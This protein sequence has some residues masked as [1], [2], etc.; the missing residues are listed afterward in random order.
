MTVAALVDASIYGGGYDFTTDTNNVKLAADV[1]EK[2]ATTFAS[3]GWSEVAAGLNAASLEVSGF[4]Q[5]GTGQVD[6]TAWTNLAADGV[7]FTVTPTEV[8][9]DVA[10]FLNT[11]ETSYSLFGPVG[12]LTP[13]SIKSPHTRG[14]YGLI[15][16][17][18]AK[19]KGNVSAT[20]ALGSA[21]QLTA[22][23]ATQYVYAVLHVFTAG[24]TITVQVQSDDASNF[25]S[26]TT[27][28]TI[29]PI[30]TAGGTLLT[31]VAGPITDD[32]YRLNV[33]AITGTFSVAGAIAVQ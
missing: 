10:Y 26:A 30:T 9:G 5:T 2:D 15:R 29:G 14:G 28:G 13:F 16:G 18:L 6:P 4:W 31:R 20:G 32:W 24:T 27:V 25:P 33:S 1:A 17:K 11:V 3:G 7:P 19:G 22:A 12:E 23:S 8:E 21:V